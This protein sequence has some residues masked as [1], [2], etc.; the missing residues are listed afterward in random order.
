MLKEQLTLKFCQ[1]FW[2]GICVSL[3]VKQATLMEVPGVV[4]SHPFA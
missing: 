1:M 4:V 3:H 2:R